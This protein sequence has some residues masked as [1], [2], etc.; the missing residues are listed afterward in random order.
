MPFASDPAWA[1]VAVAFLAVIASIV[2]V[3]LQNR[4]AWLLASASLVTTLVSEFNGPEF[5]GRRRRF[6]KLAAAHLHGQEAT[7]IGNYG[8]GVLGMF[9]HI[10]YLVRR[11]ALDRSI[12]W[13]KFGWEMV[14]YYYALTARHDLLEELRANHSDRTQYEHYQWFVTKMVASYRARGTEVID[15]EN[16]LTWMEPFLSQELSLGED[17][18]SR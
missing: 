10:A 12:V 18:K 6:A 11:G 2:G 15:F 4:K 9:E 1:G 14:G 7:L 16:N 3:F 8:F 13:N 5:S 17:G